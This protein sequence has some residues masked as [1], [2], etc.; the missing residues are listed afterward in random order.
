[1]KGLIV[2]SGEIKDYEL[3]DKIVNENEYIVCADGGFSHLL[4]IDK[5]PNVVLGDLDSIGKEELCILENKNIG[6]QKFPSMKDET[7]TELCINFLL[8]KGFKDI[9]LMG[10]IGTRLDHTLANIYLLKKIYN[11]GAKACIIDE[12]NSIYYSDERISLEKK[13][14]LFISIIP[15]SEDGIV[16]SLN[17]FLY[18]L[19]RAHLKFSSTRGISNKIIEKSG[20]I[21]FHKGEALIIESKD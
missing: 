12:N 15:I 8:K 10:V 9:T 1:M 7:D 14:G 18:P 19:K 6:I 20:D 3:L 21:I 13:E 2:S 4:K 11:F 17:G 5:F 16:V